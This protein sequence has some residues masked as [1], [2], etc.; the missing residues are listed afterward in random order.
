MMLRLLNFLLIIFLLSCNC[1]SQNSRNHYYD[2]GY[3]IG[4]GL[5]SAFPTKNVF[6]ESL[7]STQ[8]G[9]VNQTLLTEWYSPKL[10]GYVDFN[11]NFGK[12]RPIL[13]GFQY[14]WQALLKHKQS[15]VREIEIEDFYVPP[16]DYHLLRTARLHHYKC[17]FEY[18]FLQF[19][20]IYMASFADIGIGHYRMANKVTYEMK[21]YDTISRGPKEVLNRFVLTAGL[22]L[23]LSWQFSA[24]SALKLIAGYQFQTKNNF[25][26]RDYV[27]SAYA[28]VNDLHYYPEKEDFTILNTYE[29]QGRPYQTKNEYLYLQ[30]GITHR[31]E[32]ESFKKF[33]AEKPVLYLYPEDTMDV[34]I[35]LELNN[36]QVIY[37]YPNY[38]EGWNIQATPSGDLVDLLTHKKYYCLFW[39]TEGIK[40][41]KNLDVGFVVKGSEAREFLEEKLFELGLNYKESNEFIIYWLPKLQANEYNAVYFATEEYEAI[42]KL[43]IN[44]TPETVI[45]VMMLTEPLD[46]VINLKPQILP[47]TKKRKGFT[48]VEWGGMSGD[49]FIRSLD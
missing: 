14:N 29:E 16:V 20:N 18:S 4:Y 17:Y 34:S 47:E 10:G 38:R 7:R 36:H 46:H 24:K 28:T 37:S 48:A 27:S 21:F 31:F 45:R 12:I 8:T 15:Y 3:Y 5:N 23:N 35:A 1:F 19:N 43:K 42:S 26:R 13:V 11:Y 32:K 33:V 2:Q 41:A 40:I 39:E 25:V 30:L 6:L 22:G 49:F 9:I 44:P